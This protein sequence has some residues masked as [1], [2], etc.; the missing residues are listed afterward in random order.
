M[1]A[2]VTIKRAV[3]LWTGLTRAAT[4]LPS[5]CTPRVLSGRT[6][7]FDRPPSGKGDNY[8][9]CGR[10]SCETD[11]FL[12]A[13]TRSVSVHV[14]G[15]TGESYRVACLAIRPPCRPGYARI[16]AKNSPFL[17]APTGPSPLLVT[18]PLP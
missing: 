16:A 11:G 5:R 17:S 9:A 3:V 15:S 6:M 12:S 14:D 13:A 2:E 1:T 7:Y 10:K 18:P 4:S 8:Y